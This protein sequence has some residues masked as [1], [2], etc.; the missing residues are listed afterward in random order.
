[1]CDLGFEVGFWNVFGRVFGSRKRGVLPRFSRVLERFWWEIL[2]VL[3][4][5]SRL[6]RM[7]FP[8]VFG[9]EKGVVLGL[10][11]GLDLEFWFEK[12]GVVLGLG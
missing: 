2:R 11:L 10:V 12:K 1:M 5:F 8:R 6:E 7:G 9:L 4:G 3:G